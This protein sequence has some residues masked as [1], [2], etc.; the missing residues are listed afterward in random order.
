MTRIRFGLLTLLCVG[1]VSACGDAPF[2]DFGVTDD[3]LGERGAG[4]VDV[5]TTEVAAGRVSIG[6]LV[7]YTPPADSVSDDPDVVATELWER[8]PGTDAFVQAAA[9]E[10]SGAVPGVKV[11]EFLPP[12]ASH[13]TSQLVFGVS[14]GR[15]TNAYVAAFGFWSSKPYVTSRSVSQLL[16]LKIAPD[17]TSP[18]VDSADP[19]LG[20]SRF[21]DS[22]VTFCESVALGGTRAWWVVS[23]DGPTLT[24][25]DEGFRYEMLDRQS[26]GQE[27]VIELA[28]SMILLRDVEIREQGDS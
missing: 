14:T 9:N 26:I 22:D 21:T 1:L 7:W 25:Y 13:V 23:L 10:I 11:P 5:A 17:E 12:G 4:T 19:S 6:S 15:L 3:W 27:A 16:Q 28:R 20:C 2:A 24:W 8:S 18:S